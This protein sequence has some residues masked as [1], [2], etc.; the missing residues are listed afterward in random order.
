MAFF[1]TDFCP[2]AVVTKHYVPT[3]LFSLVVDVLLPLFSPYGTVT[4]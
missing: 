2:C 3:G 1:V 4:T